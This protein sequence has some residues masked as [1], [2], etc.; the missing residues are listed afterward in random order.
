MIKIILSIF[1]FIS[2]FVVGEPF[3]SVFTYNEHFDLA[4]RHYNYKR[5]KLAESEFR[6]IL[7]DRKNYSDP[8]SHLMLA[9]SQYFQN[10][11]TDCQRTCNSFLNKYSQSKYEINVRVL[12]L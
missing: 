1:L 10:K 5:Y 8:V 3:D 11:I 2:Q 4:F 9:K 12:L 6:K 7:I